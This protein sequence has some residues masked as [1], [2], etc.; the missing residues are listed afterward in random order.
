LISIGIAAILALIGVISIIV[1]FSLEKNSGTSA[2][3]QVPMVSIEPEDSISPINII[4]M[5]SDGYGPAE[6]TMGKN[7]AISQLIGSQGLFR[8]GKTHYRCDS[9]RNS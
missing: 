8:K 4:F 9:S 5:I 3:S 7:L 6:Q 2:Y 1:T